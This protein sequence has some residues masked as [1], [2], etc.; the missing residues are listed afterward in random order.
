MVLREVCYFG[1]MANVIN[2]KEEKFTKVAISVIR[3]LN[4]S[5]GHVS[6]S[7]ISR[8]SGV[9]R[10][11]IYKYIGSSKEELVKFGVKFFGN[12]LADIKGPITI[13]KTKAEF[14]EHILLA[15]WEI[16]GEFS[17]YPDLTLLYFKHC[18][19][20]TVIG[21]MIDEYEAVFINELKTSLIKLFKRKPQDAQLMAELIMSLRM[22]I[23]H[24]YTVKDLSK[25]YKM[26]DIDR[27]LNHIF[28]F[29]KR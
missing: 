18:G 3:A 15:T 17:T 13:A 14:K 7:F 12:M 22:G 11:W 21:K 16:I 19:Q 29:M 6:H 26:I 25:T 1:V 10:A 20:K 24:R 9:S 23:V 4:V 28:T 27:E 2:S 8:D 5:V